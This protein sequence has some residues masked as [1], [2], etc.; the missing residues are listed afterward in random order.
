MRD[1]AAPFDNNRSERDL[2]TMKLRQK[3]F[4]AFR[5][6]QALVNF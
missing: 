2:R 5:G 4:G 6:F 1:F 3:I